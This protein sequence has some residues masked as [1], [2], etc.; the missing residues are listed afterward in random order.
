MLAGQ[1]RPFGVHAVAIDTVTGDARRGFRLAF[2]G[3]TC[4][5]LLGS[6][7]NAR[8]QAAQNGEQDHRLK[9]HYS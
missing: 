5:R 1:V 7:A 4:D 8:L 9:L 3:R 6:E 2:L